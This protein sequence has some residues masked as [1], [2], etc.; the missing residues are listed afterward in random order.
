LYK[1]GKLM[2]A[3]NAAGQDVPDAMEEQLRKCHSVGGREMFDGIAS[4]LAVKAPPTQ[5]QSNDPAPP[6]LATDGYDVG[7]VTRL[8][9]SGMSPQ[10]HAELAQKRAQRTEGR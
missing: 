9:S 7:R 2:R 10:R 3:K 5:V 4:T 6:R 8:R 1:E